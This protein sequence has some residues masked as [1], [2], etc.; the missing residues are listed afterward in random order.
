MTNQKKR[1][2]RTK[3]KARKTIPQTSIQ[4][5]IKKQRPKRGHIVFV[6]LPCR[7]FLLA[8]FSFSLNWLFH[9]AQPAL[10]SAS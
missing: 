6:A 9:S 8:F 3:K 4:K 7:Y 1:I 10:D 5:K 2:N